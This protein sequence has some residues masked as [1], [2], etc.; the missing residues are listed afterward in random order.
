[1]NSPIHIF[2]KAQ[3]VKNRIR[4]AS[5]IENYNFLFSFTANQILDRI[6]LIKKDFEQKLWMG[7]RADKRYREN[8]ISADIIQNFNPDIIFDP[9]FLPFKDKSLDLIVNCLDL[10]TI[11]DLP[12]TLIQIFRALKPD[13]LFIGTMIGGESLYELRDCLQRAEIELTGGISPRIAPFADKQ[14]VGALMQRAGYA[15]PVIDSEKI[16]VTYPTLIKLLH[17]LR[18]MGEGNAIHNRNKKTPNRALFQRTEDIYFQNYCDK[19]GRMITTFEI[20][21]MAGWS[22]HENQQKPLKPGSAE[23]SLARELGTQ[24]HEAGETI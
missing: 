8:F 7:C 3:I 6:S 1:M 22:P 14:D 5:D 13:G 12:G 15:L 11:N 9:E 18:C 4:S 21:F 19:E 23:Q 2:D 16:I 20:I 10:H 24:E 17:D